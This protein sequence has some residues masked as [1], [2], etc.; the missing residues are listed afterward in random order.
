MHVALSE[1]API[2]LFS[3]GTLNN[4]IINVGKIQDMFHLVVPIFEVPAD[5]VKG[6]GAHGMTNMATG[7]HSHT[8]D[9]HRDLSWL[10]GNKHFFLAAQGVINFQYHG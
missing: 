8:A 1:R 5:H 4:F 7:V 3:L 6:E 2:D 9:I 10:L